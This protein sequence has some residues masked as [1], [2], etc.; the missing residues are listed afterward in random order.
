MAK[1]TPVIM[2]GGAGTRLWPVSRLAAPKPFHRLGTEHTLIQETA[3]R[4]Q[5]PDFNP[6]MVICNQAQGALAA[7]QLA[8][9]GAPA[10]VVILEPEGRNTAACVVAAAA[11]VAHH[12]PDA[13]LML[14]PGDG[15]IT[16]VA[17][18]QAAARAGIEAARQGSLV[19]FGLKP[20]HPETGYGYIRAA[21]D[22]AVAPVA[23]FVEKPDLETAKRYV[24]DTAMS[25]N[26]GMFLFKAQAMLNEARRHA[27]EIARVA[28]TAA[29]DGT[30]EGIFFRLDE[31]YRQA[32]SISIDYAVM[33]KT[34]KAAVVR[35]D[36]GWSDVGAWR[37]LWELAAHSGDG[38]VL[39]GDALAVDSHGVFV[40]TDGPTV[41]VAGLKDVVV[42][43]EDGVV[44]VAPK[45]DPAAVRRVVEVLK[46]QGREELL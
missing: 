40:R 34:D 27:G 33:E 16:D 19:V 39:E 43:V 11:V 41:A 22:E 38:N 37:A 12:D 14:L 25:W 30:R 42:V 26:A 44:L 17:A 35:C 8:E 4:S 32:P 15:V 29:A 13:L 18:Y 7:A 28:E 21:T 31:G 46:A 23:A 1:I 5:G 36:L 3:L 2:S 9:V 24:A 20:T 6:A 10:S 45:D